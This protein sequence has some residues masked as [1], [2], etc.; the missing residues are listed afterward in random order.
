[1]HRLRP[2][3]N[4]PA[5]PSVVRR[6]VLW[7]TVAGSGVLMVWLAI[8][9]R[10]FVDAVRAKAALD[11]AAEMAALEADLQADLAP[12]DPTMPRAI[13]HPALVPPAWRAPS[14]PPPPSVSPPPS[15]PART[16][17]RPATPR[18]RT[19]ASQP[20]AT[21]AIVA[22]RDRRLTLPV[23][24]VEPTALYDSF[25]DPRS[26]GRTHHAIDISAPR[27]TPVVAVEAGRVTRLF[28][29]RL[30]GIALDLVD[31][32]GTYLYYYAHL[33]GYAP[34]LRAGDAVARGQILGHVGTTGNAPVNVPHLHFAIRILPPD[35][36]RS[37]GPAVNP[38]EVLRFGVTAR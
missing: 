2:A 33:D 14:T 26:G 1:M 29:S 27:G 35:G 34:G 21:Q 8:E 10:H 36:S 5:M 31:A 18:P 11:P 37:R 30:G 16:R 24:G 25:Y 7:L 12:T 3:S 38:Y 6:G 22:L 28:E 13:D 4:R 9:V 15:P 19:S 23:Q 20:S 32:T 17:W